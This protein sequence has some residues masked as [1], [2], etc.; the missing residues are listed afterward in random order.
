M[1]LQDTARD[2]TVACAAFLG[3]ALLT[4]AICK[5]QITTTTLTPS[6]PLHSQPPKVLPTWAKILYDNP[7]YKRI[8]LREWNDL[9]W[10]KENGWLGRDLCHN[11]DGK[12]VRILDYFWDQENNTL[13]G[14]VWFGNEAGT[15]IQYLHL[16]LYIL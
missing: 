6:S 10:R 7:K 3:G 12:A 15:T 11:P 13:I 4:S 9:A 16:T 1:E 14:I 5:R 2:A 8:L